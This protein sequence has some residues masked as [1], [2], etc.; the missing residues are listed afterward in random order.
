M[1]SIWCTQVLGS[2]NERDES[3]SPKVYEETMGVS[4]WATLETSYGEMDNIQNNACPKLGGHGMAY[5]TNDAKE[6]YQY[7][8]KKKITI[9]MGMSSMAYV[10]IAIILIACA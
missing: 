10:Q 1:G 4:S 9:T 2:C 7:H 3:K 8:H 6:A 5:E